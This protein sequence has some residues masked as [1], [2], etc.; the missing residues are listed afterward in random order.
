MSIGVIRG[1]IT[2]ALFVS[3]IG[4][5]IWAWSGRRKADFDLAAQM[6]LQD[7]EIEPAAGHSS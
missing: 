2:L 1:V 4:L 7:S 6:P 5:W 3:F